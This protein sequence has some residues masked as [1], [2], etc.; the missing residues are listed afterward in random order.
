[1]DYNP[2]DPDVIGNEWVGIAPAAYVMDSGTERGYR[3]ATTAPTTPVL[4]HYFLEAEPPSQVIAQYPLIALYPSGQEA[5]IGEVRKVVLPV[6]SAT[7]TGTGMGTSG[8]AGTTVV[9]ALQSSSDL[10]YIFFTNSTGVTIDFGFAMSAMSPELAGKRIINVSIVYA[11]NGGWSEVS[12]LGGNFVVLSG[13][14][15]PVNYGTPFLNSGD[16]FFATDIPELS[17]ISLGEMN[18]FPRDVIARQQSYP[19]RNED[20][21][22]FDPAASIPMRWRMTVAV[23]E[24]PR[25][26]LSYL[27]LEITYA[28][29]NRLYYGAPVIGFDNNANRYNVPGTNRVILRTTSTMATGASMPAGD[30]SITSTMGDPGDRSIVFGSAFALDTALPTAQALRELYPLPNSDFRGIEVDRAERLGDRADVDVSRVIPYIAYTT[31]LASPASSVDTHAYGKQSPV[32]VFTGSTP[33]QAWIAGSADATPYPWV[34]FWARRLSETC[35][36]VGPLTVSAGTGSAVISCGDFDELPEIADG[37]KQVTLRFPTPPVLGASG[38][39]TWSSPVVT[40]GQWQLLSDSGQESN[41]S[42]NYGTAFASPSYPPFGFRPTD[43]IA[44]LFMQDPPTVTGVGTTI[45]T[46]PL[47]PVSLDCGTPG[48][49]IPTGMSFV[50]L[51]WTPVT[52]SAPSAVSTFG[53]Y[54][55]Q[56]QD[57]VSSQWETTHIL[58][59]PET[60]VIQDREARV[61]VVSRYRMRVV[62]VY[63][64]EGP[65]SATFSATIPATSPSLWLFCSNWDLFG[66]YL[67]AAPEVGE[68]QPPFQPSYYEAAGVTYQEMYGRNNRTAFHGTERGGETFSVTL[69]SNQGAGSAGGMGQAYED[70]RTL[71]WNRIGDTYAWTNPYVCVRDGVGNRWY[72]QVQVPDARFDR[73]LPVHNR[74]QLLNVTVVEVLDDPAPFDQGVG[75]QVMS[76]EDASVYLPSQGSQGESS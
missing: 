54:E 66:A 60:T 41:G 76:I 12:P 19:W 72:A 50:G 40:G 8:P 14:A 26:E 44:F 34:R 52:T 16:S 65:F 18:P 10:A 29:E 27:G 43:D 62:S 33:T 7:V 35:E 1:M 4:G 57:D 49:C 3:F 24:G 11:A 58:Y 17:R 45:F 30:Y 15:Y 2:N 68:T 42:S 51:S 63:G 48:Q 59:N 61:G 31:S 64:I 36:G 47:T 5:S 75:T 74:I 21:Q 23:G 25:V 70:F 38:T 22:R 69:L 28:V 55:I 32:P 13:S 71:C 56:R 67:F 53:Y 37:W 73:R 9:S 20:L 46:Q 6:S 39:V